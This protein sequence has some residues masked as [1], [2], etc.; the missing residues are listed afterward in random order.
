MYCQHAAAV[1]FSVRKAKQTSKIGTKDII[2]K[3]FFV[4]SAAGL[5][6]SGKK[7]EKIAEELLTEESSSVKKK[8]DKVGE[9]Q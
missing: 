9:F 2:N 4:C 5:R 8:Q 7:K 1:G 6:N 3:K